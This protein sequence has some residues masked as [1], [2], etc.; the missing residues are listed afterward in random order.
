M[1]TVAN[2]VSLPESATTISSSLAN[3]KKFKDLA[4]IFVHGDNRELKKKKK[5]VSKL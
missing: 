4:W 5:G 2:T 1:Q 3:G